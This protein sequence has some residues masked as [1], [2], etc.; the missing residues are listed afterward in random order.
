[1][2]FIAFLSSG[3][4]GEKCFGV[5][6]NCVGIVLL[7]SACFGLCLDNTEFQ[8]SFPE[9][10]IWG[11]LGKSAELPCDVTPPTPSDSVKM[12]FW[13]KDNIG[14]PWYSLDARSG[15]SHASHLTISGDLGNRLYFIMDG[16]P[17]Q[18]RLKIENISIHDQGIYRCRVDFVNSPTRNFQVNLSLIE[19][20]SS[21]RVFDAEGREIT[22]NS[23][24]GPFLEEHDLFLSCQVNGGKPR[25]T[26]TWWHGNSLL[27]GVVDTSSNSFTTVNQLFISHVSRYLKGAR[28]ECR[29]TSSDTA[30]HITRNIP[31]IVYLKP[32]KVKIVSPNEL[33]S[34][35]KSQN[36]K[37]ETSGSYPPAK[38]TWLLDGKSIKQSIVT[39]EETEFF[40]AS[41]LTLTVSADDDGKELICRAEN[42]RFPGS[43]IQDSRLISVAYPPKVRVQLDSELSLPAK[44]GSEVRLKCEGQANPSANNYRWY[45]N[46]HIVQL[47]STSGVFPID[48]VLIMKHVDRKSAG[49]YACSATNSEG[50]TYSAT[51]DLQVQFTPRCRKGYEEIR[52]GAIPQKKIKVECHVESVPEVNKFYWTYNTSRNVLRVQGSRMENKGSIS[53]LYFE[54]PSSENEVHSLS[55]WAA[56]DLGPQVV[57]CLFLLVP[58]STPERPRNCIYTNATVGGTLKVTC[59]PGRDG[60]LPQSFVLE[61][62]DVTPFNPPSSGV[63]TLS[64]QG[65]DAPPA[66]RFLG[67]RPE[68]EI[69][70]LQPG[71]EYQVSVF[72]ENARGRSTPYEIMPSIRVP[73]SDTAESVKNHEL[74]QPNTSNQKVSTNLTPIY[75]VL[76]SC[77]VILVIVI[78]TAVSILA[79]RKPSTEV[80][81]RRKN[82]RKPNNMTEDFELNSEAG[83]GSGFH[84]RSAQY[85][86]SMYGMDDV[87]RRISNIVDRPD[88]ILS[89]RSL[90]NVDE[91]DQV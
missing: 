8:K 23:S 22:S 52:V 66:F 38:L 1:M 20:P 73:L 80:V 4:S 58:A 42:P 75:I 51:F 91:E 32:N 5:S 27:D 45:H 29:A 24:A 19:Q 39:E 49:Q 47:N 26:V 21:L 84:R 62:K 85:R 71:R 53:T 16:E 10:I 2:G 46:G 18:A 72:A 55:C 68:F 77:A 83:F 14:M 61:V 43:R 15:L 59:R 44:E 54:I 41:I 82:T 35:R 56:N 79:C 11:L 48:D 63:S 57:P 7:W 9:K 28:F 88:L 17:S 3:A 6:W 78:I 65:E 60:G 13:Y 67:E 37:C 90:R 25:P 87:E 76:S 40:T 30:G 74:V 89:P 31:L 81:V 64:D 69:H 70:S 34:N 33:M 86:A 36:I 50:E 12:V